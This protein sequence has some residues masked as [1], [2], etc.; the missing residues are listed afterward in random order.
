MFGCDEVTIQECWDERAQSQ[1]R[2]RRELRYYAE[3]LQALR[4]E[5]DSL[6]TYVKAEQSLLKALR[7]LK[8]E[9]GLTVGVVKHVKSSVCVTFGYNTTWQRMTTSTTLRA[10]TKTIQKRNPVIRRA[11]QLNWDFK[12]L[13]QYYRSLPPPHLLAYKTLVGKT[14]VLVKVFGRLRF[15][16]LMPLD[17]ERDEPHAEGWDFVTLIKMHTDPEVVTIPRLQELALCP[18]RHLLQLRDRIRAKKAETDCMEDM[19]FWMKEDG[20][21]MSYRNVR[22]ECIDSMQAAGIGDAK[23]HHLKHAAITELRRR[24]ATMEEI[25]N[26]ARHKHGTYTWA[27]NYLDAH[28]ASEDSV[29]KLVGV[30]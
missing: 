6:R 29:R 4:I 8:N 14:I 17:A 20:E 27:N 7:W 30:K 5:L 22:Q 9:K 26:Y 21:K 12:P 24:A 10:A 23:P 19:V 3:A 2:F 25:V 16:E 1:D 18:T 13:W 28:G 11:L 15:T